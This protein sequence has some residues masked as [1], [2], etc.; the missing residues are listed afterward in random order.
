MK[1]RIITSVVALCILLPVL[2]FADTPAL[3]AGL[4][5]CALLAVY[6][7]LHCLGLGRSLAIGIPFCPRRCW[8]C[9]TCSRC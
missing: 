9:S 3:P 8:G 4:A 6:E 7:M 5:L 2:I 1:K